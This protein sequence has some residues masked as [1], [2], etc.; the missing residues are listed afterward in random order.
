MYACITLTLDETPDHSPSLPVIDRPAD[1]ADDVQIWFQDD[2]GNQIVL[3]GCR[4]CLA[5]QF[6]A[7]ARALGDPHQGARRRSG[8]RR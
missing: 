4:A 6:A 1:P 5:N 7:L 8:R 2:E 3:V